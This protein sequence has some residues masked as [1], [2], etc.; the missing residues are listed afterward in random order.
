MHK[1]T[2]TRTTIGSPR[3]SRVRFGACA[4]AFLMALVASFAIHAQ[5]LTAAEVE[6][7][8]AR[9]DAAIA[10][11]DHVTLGHY[12]SSDLRIDVNL[13]VGI[14]RATIKLNKADFLRQAR[15][16]WAAASDYQYRRAGAKTRL[17][18]DGGSATVSA[19][20]FERITIAEHV[21]TTRTEE[22]LTL[23]RVGKDIVVTAI[24]GDALQK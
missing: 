14:Q 8:V 12:L 13:R 18:A 21:V 6:A 24:T 5:V 17:A 7:T 19:T 3:I 16:A 11:R 23:Q 22:V 9:M 2:E 20:V 1:Q 15:D 4:C 10:K